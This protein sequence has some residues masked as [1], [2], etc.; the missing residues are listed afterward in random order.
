MQLTAQHLVRLSLVH[1]L[2]IQLFQCVLVLMNRVRRT[3]CIDWNR[4]G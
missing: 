4:A 1:S 3:E 2:P